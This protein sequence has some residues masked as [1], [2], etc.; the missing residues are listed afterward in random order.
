MAVEK[1]REH[2]LLEADFRS[3]E[4]VASQLAEDK[5]AAA[6]SGDAE[7]LKFYQEQYDH[8]VERR[9]EARIK[10]NAARLS[11]G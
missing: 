7:K 11:N 4:E 2:Q 6:Q 3:W 1:W 8:A 5:K 9:R 10:W